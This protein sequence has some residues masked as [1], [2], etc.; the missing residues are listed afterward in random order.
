MEKRLNKKIEIYITDFKDN[1]REKII[2][3]NS[4][5]IK[6]TQLLQFICDYDRLTFN[7]EDFNKRKRIKNFVPI[8]IRCCAMRA[9]NEQCTRR[10][11]G[12]FD[13][14]GTHIKG[15][16]HGVVDLLVTDNNITTQNIEVWAHD[17]GG[18]IYYIDNFNNVYDTPDIIKN[19]INPKIIAKYCKNGD[20]YSIPEFNC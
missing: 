14:C 2:N 12:D 19:K 13:Y 16:P 5:D 20:I 17:I 3:L 10:K 4:N 1:V 9:N 6:I 7:K 18:I 11:K 15:T 8:Y